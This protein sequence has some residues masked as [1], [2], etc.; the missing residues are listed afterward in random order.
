MRL[1]HSDKLS[2]NL[3]DLDFKFHTANASAEI[4]RAENSMGEAESQNSTDLKS[5]L[6]SPFS[7]DATSSSL[8]GAGSP[9]AKPPPSRLP[10]PDQFLGNSPLRRIDRMRT[11]F[12]EHGKMTRSELIRILGVSPNTATKDLKT[13]CEEGL[14]ER[15]EPSTST[16]SH[17]F[18]LKNSL[19]EAPSASASSD[20]QA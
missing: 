12:A 16:R 18:V 4:R 3:D 6:P 7:P 20:Q 5:P 2:Y 10:M 15:V 11:L 14:I 13:L 8:R 9:F 1:M 19:K 17:Y